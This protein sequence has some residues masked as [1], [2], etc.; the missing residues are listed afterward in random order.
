[1]TTTLLRESG[2]QALVSRW[3]TLS[4][5]ALWMEV[6]GH[7]LAREMPRGQKELTRKN[8]VAYLERELRKENGE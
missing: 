8:I 2:I 3:K 4:E 5:A 6:V 1:M 7:V